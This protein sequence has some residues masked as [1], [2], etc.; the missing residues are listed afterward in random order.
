M[1]CQVILEF[2]AAP[3]RVA[4][5]QQWLKGVLPDT[6]AFDGCQTLYCIQNQED[7]EVVLIVEQWDSRQHYERYLAWRAERGDMEVFGAMMAGPPNIRFFDYF[8]V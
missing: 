1:S 6:R 2:R 8:R 5:V 3:G 4:D 7:P